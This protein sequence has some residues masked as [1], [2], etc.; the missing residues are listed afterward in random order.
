MSTKDKFLELSQIDGMTTSRM[1]LELQVSRQRVHQ[2]KEKYKVKLA[3]SPKGPPRGHIKTSHRWG[4]ERRIPPNW[5]GA[6]GELTAAV[7][8]IKMGFYVHQ[9]V[10]RTGP[11]DLIAYHDGA[12]HRIEV[13]CI[14]KP[15]QRT[16]VEWREVDYL[17][18]VLPDGTVEWSPEA[19]RIED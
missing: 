15:G 16:G 18:S 9:A 13:R 17:A 14:R 11:F 19:P 5:I 6:A 4:G 2:L 12:F 7:E 1:A 8:L 3:P 10:A